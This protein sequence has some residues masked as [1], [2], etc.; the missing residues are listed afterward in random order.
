MSNYY[1]KAILLENCPYSIAAH[2]LLKIHN[3][4]SE[5]VWV[6]NEEKHKYKTDIINTFPQLYLQK[7]KNIGSVLVG[8]YDNLNYF[9]NTFKNNKLNDTLIN[10]FMEENKWSK[11]AVLRFIQ[12]IN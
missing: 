6:N 5:V 9:I 4:P 11:K 10:K 1:I 12:L 3:I 7:R 2:E 8:G